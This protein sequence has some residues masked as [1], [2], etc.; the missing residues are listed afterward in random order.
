[1]KKQ[2]LKDRIY[3]LKGNKAPL[4]FML[5]S[6]NSQRNPLLYFDGKRNKPLRYAKNQ[7][8]PFQDEQD[9]YAIVEP[10]VFEDG[11][12]FVSR[13]NPVLQEF[14][15]YHPGNN[16]IYVEVD[17]EKDATVDVEKLDYELEAQ[18]AAKDLELETLETIARV[19]L[20]MNV[21]KMTSAEI[22]RDVRL[23]AKRYPKDF[24]ESLND[25][26]LVIQNKCA[27]FFDERL[28]TMRNK[29]KDVYF[30][31]TNNKKKILTVPFGENVLNTLSVW[32]QTDD[33][34]ETLRLLEGKLED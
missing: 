23:F 10:I 34:I 9:G 28:I 5:N 30:N 16:K 3:K 6:R 1:M 13:T 27:K 33:G 25:P 11:M 14:L 7:D 26:L 22:K 20:S 31:L 19:V 18:V 12:L 17:N 32:M 15:N 29:N 21:D 4:S 2:E 8:T 24:L